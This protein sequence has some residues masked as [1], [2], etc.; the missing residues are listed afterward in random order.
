[1]LQKFDRF[2]PPAK[3]PLSASQTP[4]IANVENLI[5]EKSNTCSD[6]ESDVEP[7]SDS[8]EDYIPRESDDTELDDNDDDEDAHDDSML[9]LKL[10]SHHTQNGQKEDADRSEHA[11][12]TF[13]SQVTSQLC[14]NENDHLEEI[15]DSEQPLCTIHLSEK[16][17]NVKYFDKRPYCMFCGKQQT[18]IQRHWLSVHSEEREVIEIKQLKDKEVRCKRITKLRNLGNHLHNMEVFREQK[19]ELMVTYRSGCRHQAS[20]S[21][22][23]PCEHCFGY[24]LKSELYRHRCKLQDSTVKGRVAANASLLVPPPR[25]MSSQVFQLLNG[26]SDDSIVRA[27]RTDSLIVDYAAKLIAKKG[28][29]KKIYIRDKVREVARFL[30][31]MRKQQNLAGAAL[32]ECVTPE[33]FQQCLTAVK[34]LAGFSEQTMTY[35][36]PSLALKIGHALQKLSMIVKRNAI[37]KKK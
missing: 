14:S 16:D 6:S 27:A 30:V 20:A 22:Y 8:D 32:T 34:A 19:G 36:T 9:S 4:N 28:M 35:R 17:A 37:E 3:Y 26:M 31:E 11:Q 5:L 18:Q 15:S 12:N 13:G 1:M 23:L 33:K 7:L 2:L 21:D 24:F 25:G 10:S 29:Q